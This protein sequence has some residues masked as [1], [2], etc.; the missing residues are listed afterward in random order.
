M[1]NSLITLNV[2][3]NIILLIIHFFIAALIYFFVS[4]HTI[5]SIYIPLVTQ[6]YTTIVQN[7]YAQYGNF[8]TLPETFRHN[9]RQFIGEAFKPPMVSD[10]HGT[11]LYPQT[12]TPTQITLTDYPYR[13]TVYVGDGTFVY[14]LPTDSFY[15]YP[16]MDQYPSEFILVFGLMII[17]AII[18]NGIATYIATMRM[19]RPISKLTQLSMIPLANPQ[20]FTNQLTA[21]T[22]GEII[23][24]ARALDERDNEITRQI[25]LHRQLNADI[26]HELR[27]PL[28]VINGYIEA[29]RDGMLPAT[30]NR[31]A[32]VHT[33]IQMLYKLVND[34]RTLS[35]AEVDQLTLTLTKTRLITL[36]SDAFDALEPLCTEK[37][38]R[39]S[40]TCD[41]HDALIEIDKMQMISV[42]Y[43]IVENAIRHTAINGAITITATTTH[44]HVRIAISDTGTGIDPNDIVHLFER[45]NRGSNPI[46]NGSGLG[47][48]IVHAIVTAHHGTI[49]LDSTLGLGTTLTII[50]P[51][52]T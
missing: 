22:A 19:L 34:L 14:L 51:L 10:A 48:A 44:E 1:K 32:I 24:L 20:H 52:H 37:D 28:N 30:P 25:N 6:R 40:Y 41:H 4:Y 13:T 38:I 42:L 7:H 33:E 26:S 50:L 46:G 43:N 17:T 8:T 18:F 27:N 31:L 21:T 5:T 36:I 47:L 29:M 12:T 49:T 2:K 16:P 11:L 45:F 35:L 3:Q 15:D 9:Y 39:F 23:Q